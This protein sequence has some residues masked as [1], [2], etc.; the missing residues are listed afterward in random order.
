MGNGMSEQRMDF[1]G[2]E[3]TQHYDDK[4][5]RIGTTHM[6]NDLF[7]ETYLENRDNA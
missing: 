7:G 3:Y 2:D 1:L 5:N 6:R 4:G